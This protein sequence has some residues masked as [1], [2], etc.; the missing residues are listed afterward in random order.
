MSIVEGNKINHQNNENESELELSSEGISLASKFQKMTTV[1]YQMQH[2]ESMN[3][4]LDPEEFD[5]CLIERDEDLNNFLNEICN[6]FLP[7]GIYL[8]TCESSS[9]ALNTLNNA[10]ITTTYMTLYNQKK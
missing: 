8:N 6:I 5:H 10:G 7:K 2:K 4:I 9:E 1:F 3:L